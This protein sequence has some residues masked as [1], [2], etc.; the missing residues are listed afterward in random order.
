[1]SR[2]QVFLRILIVVLASW[3][4]GSGS[5]LGL[6]Y[7]GL[8]ALAA[9]LTGLV[10]PENRRT[11]SACPRA[12]AMTPDSNAAAPRLN[13][14]GRTAG[15]PLSEEAQVARQGRGVPQREAQRSSSSSW[16]AGS[17]TAGWVCRGCWW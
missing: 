17:W 9:I 4:L 3:I 15:I 13:D 8:P 12:N 7:L 16:R 6:V 11:R 2:A 5:G 10:G 1:M 14:K